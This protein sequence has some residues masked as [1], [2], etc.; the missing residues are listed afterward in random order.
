MLTKKDFAEIWRKAEENGRVTN[1]VNKP[2]MGTPRW[3]YELNIR[4]IKAG[5]APDDFRDK[6]LDLARQYGFPEE[7]VH[8]AFQIGIRREYDK[9]VEGLRTR[10]ESG[11]V[12]GVSPEYT[13]R[14]L[15]DMAQ[16]YGFSTEP[17]DEVLKLR[18][19]RREAAAQLAIGR[20]GFGGNTAMAEEIAAKHG[21]SLDELEED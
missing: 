14:K 2:K 17:L 11:A 1:L 10:F 3:E 4:F 12:G 5:I 7:P 21:F 20:C 16:K 18:D 9:D 13:E 15:R 6:A 19:P 8:E